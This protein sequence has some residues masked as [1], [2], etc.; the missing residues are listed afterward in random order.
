MNAQIPLVGKMITFENIS[1]VARALKNVSKRANLKCTGIY[2]ILQVVRNLVQVTTGFYR[3]LQVLR[4]L[5][6]VARNL[7]QVARN[8]VQ[9]ARN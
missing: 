3:L 9:V 5:V 6:Q 8:L 1:A 7:V 2:R 4:N